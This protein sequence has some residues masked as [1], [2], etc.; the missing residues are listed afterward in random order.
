MQGWKAGFGRNSSNAEGLRQGGHR[1]DEVLPTEVKLNRVAGF[2]QHRFRSLV[3]EMR[4][5]VLLAQMGQKE[6]S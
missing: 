2:F 4:K 1:A 5:I 6:G 3:G